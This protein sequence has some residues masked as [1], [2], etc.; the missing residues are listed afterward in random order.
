MQFEIILKLKSEQKIDLKENKVEGR[1]RLLKT[2]LN[3]RKSVNT[4]KNGNISIL[5]IMFLM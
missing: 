4:D 1:I 2:V 5:K 3:S